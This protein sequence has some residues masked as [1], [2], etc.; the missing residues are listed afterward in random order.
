MAGCTVVVTRSKA[1]ASALS[2]QLESL[3][4]QVEEIATIE[5]T[6][7]PDGGEALRVALASGS[8]DQLVVAS[9]NGARVLVQTVLDAEIA[10][11]S[12]A[13]VACVGPST[14][15][16]VEASGLRVNVVPDQAVA[17]G[18]VEAIGSPRSRAERLLLVQAEVARDALERG[19]RAHGWRVERVT[20]YRTIDATVGDRDRARARSADVVTFTS[21]STVERFVRLLG[22]DALP[23]AVVTIGPITSGTARELGVTVDAEA[24][25]HTIAG[26]VD[27][28][29]RWRSSPGHGA[30][31]GALDSAPW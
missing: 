31:D 17:E 20:A 13:P 8:H 23:P 21:S 2:D 7:P 9:P 3:G 16:V 22:V 5:I 4:A 27:A 1:Q 19:L 30:A 14:A 24:D 6:P 10:V 25:P 15:A 11:D 29:V 12:V 18:L 28:V 26:L